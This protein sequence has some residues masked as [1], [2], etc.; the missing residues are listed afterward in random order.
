MWIFR[1]GCKTTF[2][3]SC[4]CYHLLQI[5]ELLQGFLWGMLWLVLC[6][7]TQ[8]RLIDRLLLIRK[9]VI[10]G[11]GGS[12]STA[13]TPMPQNL[14]K[15]LKVQLFLWTILF[16]YGRLKWD[17]KI[18]DWWAVWGRKLSST[19]LREGIDLPI[20]IGENKPFA[21]EIMK[22]WKFGSI[23]LRSIGNKL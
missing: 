4:S 22:L 1:N 12:G 20:P 13:K 7:T 6:F 2:L 3:K 15:I 10:H 14:V 9:P 19:V 16:G 5:K 11:G 17:I 21:K 23:K 8:I 18:N